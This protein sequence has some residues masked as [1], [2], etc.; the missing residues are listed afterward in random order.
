MSGLS[1]FLINLKLTPQNFY[2]MYHYSFN[3][4][5]EKTYDINNIKTCLYNSLNHF[6]EISKKYPNHVKGILTDR[7]PNNILV[8]SDLSLSDIILLLDRDEKNYALKNFTKYP[9]E[10]F[11]PDLDIDNI[12]SKSYTLQVNRLD[13]DALCAKINHI[14]DGFLFSLALHDDLKKNQLSIFE[15]KE[16]E[17]FIDNMYGFQANSEY[18]I[19]KIEDK[20]QSCKVGFEK[21][22]TLFNNPIYFD[23]FEEEFNS[24]TE[25]TQEAIYQKFSRAKERSLPTNF[26]ADKDLIK[27]V[28]IEKEKE[29]KIYELRIFEPVCVRLYFFEESKDKVYLASV[30]KKPA[31]KVQSND[32]KTSIALIK[33]LIKIK[34]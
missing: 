22:I 21:F 23:S 2:S 33:S 8:N 29:I 9:I 28:T 1:V 3:D 31:K 4:C 15:N 7:S 24:L 34:K 13:Y 6:K 25:N 17:I 10:D 14:H 27:D 20:I 5:F 32:I 11:Y 12:L 26:S 18:N 16:N 19:K 30:S